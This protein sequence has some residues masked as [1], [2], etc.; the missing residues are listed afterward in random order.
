MLFKQIAVI[1][2]ENHNTHCVSTMQNSSTLNQAVYMV[3]TTLFTL[4]GAFVT[5]RKR[6]SWVRHV[7]P[8]VRVEQFGSHWTD[9]HEILYFRTVRNPV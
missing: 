1:Y 3:T 5:L 7:Y 9:F 2:Y 8:S 6:G 4:L